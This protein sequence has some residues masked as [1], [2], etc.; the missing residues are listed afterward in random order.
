VILS[1]FTVSEFI[2]IKFFFFFLSQHRVNVLQ[3]EHKLGEIRH[4]SELKFGRQQLVEE[5]GSLGE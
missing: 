1:F 2:Y 4:F 3:G 5:L